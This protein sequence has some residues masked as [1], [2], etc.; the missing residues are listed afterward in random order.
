MRTWI[1]LALSAVVFL[2]GCTGLIVHEKGDLEHQI[3]L[4][5]LEDRAVRIVRDGLADENALVRNHAIE[6]VASTQRRQ[7]M[8]KV[9]SL[10]SDS[11]IAVRF[12]AATAV[13]DLQYAA[14]EYPVRHM[15]ND[16]D[17]NVQIAAAYALA[18]LG[19]PENVDHIRKATKSTDQTVRANA[20]LLLGRLGDRND[21]PLVYEMLYSSE[22]TDQVR[23][24]AV[25]SIAMLKD[26]R[27]YRD[28]LW[29]LLISKFA[30]DR[31]MGI[32]GM[33]ALG[34]TEA[35][36]AII[37]ML[38]D[39]VVEVRLCAAG[40]LGRLDDPVGQ[41]EVIAYFERANPNLD[42][43]SVANT[44]AAMAVGHIGTE[45]L[46]KYLPRLLQSRSRVVQLG[47]AQSV[48]LL[49]GSR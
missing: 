35:K 17:A 34:T 33:A 24:Q 48:L 36:D 19:K 29:A 44:L 46:K 41:T 47:A 10:L 28:R 13:G 20:V 8:P 1:T 2:A 49:A 23:F 32:R 15:L 38:D 6:V 30:D 26:Q 16:R 27:I 14:G 4:S 31:V 5:P 22:S 37:T 42:E 43:P 7:L 25:E 18:R 9:L 3:D 45:P 12:A 39:E 11:S 40:E 21:L